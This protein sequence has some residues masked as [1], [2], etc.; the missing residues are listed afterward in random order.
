MKLSDSARAY[1]HSLGLE[2]EPPSL[3]FLERIC[4]AHL[5]TYPFENIS[6]LIYFRDHAGDKWGN[7]LPSLETFVNNHRD[8]HYGGTCYVLNSNLKLLLQ[9]VGFA[10]YHIKLGNEHIGIIV[11]IADD[12][13]YVD[14]GAAAPFFKPV[15]F[16]TDAHNISSF[17]GDRVHLLPEEP[18]QH[19]YKYVRYIQDKQSGKTWHFDSRQPYQIQDFYSIVS[20]SNRP[21]TTFMT[22]LRCQ[23]YQTKNEQSLSLVNNKFGIRYASGETA[24]R[25]LTSVQEIQ[26][27]LADEFKLPRLPVAEAIA[28]LETLEVD[29]FANT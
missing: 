26:Q 9:A 29:I 22:I 15:R 20:E 21:G 7:P 16:E 1:L 25:T 23:L 24:V 5:N 13:Y 3:S 10:C 8:Y 27:V 12:R 11:H 4:L 14:C 2:Q 6:K 19:Q 28:V 17:G 18:Q